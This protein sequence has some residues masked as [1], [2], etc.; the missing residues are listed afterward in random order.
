MTRVLAIIAAL[1]CSHASAYLGT[2]EPSPYRTSATVT[3]IDS[4]LAGAS[5]AIEATKIQPLYAL[6]A[7]L[8]LQLTECALSDPP[9]IIAPITF[10]PG[11][12]YAFATLLADPDSLLGHS[13]RHVFDGDF[14]IAGV[15]FVHANWVRSAHC[16][17]RRNLPRDEPETDVRPAPE[18]SAQPV[19]LP[20][21]NDSTTCVIFIDACEVSYRD[22][23]ALVRECLK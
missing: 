7:P 6:A 9:T 21:K 5:C 8:M 20:A 16:E 1:W 3:F 13:T 4:Q 2:Y 15:P 18:R 14:H 23:G 12:L 17:A 19:R 10:G 22:L 11:S